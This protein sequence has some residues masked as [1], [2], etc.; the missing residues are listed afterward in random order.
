MAGI[1]LHIPFCSSKCHYCNFFSTVSLKYEAEIIAAMQQELKIRKDYL[2]GE[3]VESIYFGGGTPSFIDKESISNFLKISKENF[4]LSSDIE[5][6]LEANPDDLNPEKLD[7]FL[8]MGVNRLSMGTQSFDDKILQKLNRRHDGK[9][10]ENS[11]RMAQKA[12]FQ[13]ISIDLIYGIPGLDKQ[14]WSDSIDRALAMKIQ[15][16]SAYHLTV[17]EG[18]ALEILIRKKKYPQPIEDEG[19]EHFDMLQEKIQ[20]AAFEAYEISN[21]AK[22]GM[23]SRHNT[24]YWRR[25]NYL[26]IGPS[27]HSFDGLSRQWNSTGIKAYLNQ[28]HE[29]KTFFQ[30]EE[31][32][33]N[34]RF[35]EFVMLGLRSKWG[36]NLK[37]I[38]KIFGKS[39]ALHCKKIGL[40][41]LDTKLLIAEKD[42]YF[43]SQEGRKHA[44]GIASDYFL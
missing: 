3:A 16:I 32:Q 5:I 44:D 11:V 15:H 13:N 21:Y 41:Y 38:Q 22:N 19:L 8:E 34:D 2:Q 40:K 10:A 26:G 24:N 39:Y 17:E 12:G 43:L 28:M 14:L 33:L 42:Q 20:Q 6:T 30:R 1:Y 37:E 23:Y 27:A 4:N 29:Q 35:N 36:I 25:K 18:T 31:L 9:A 7:A